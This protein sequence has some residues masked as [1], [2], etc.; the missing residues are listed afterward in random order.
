MQT[1]MFSSVHA[2][3][4]HLHGFMSYTAALKTPQSRTRYFVDIGNEKRRRI[5]CFSRLP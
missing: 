5:S 4:V 2:N 3:A 1:L